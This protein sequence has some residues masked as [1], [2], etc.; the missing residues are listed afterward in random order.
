[1]FL[2]Y[3]NPGSEE[4]IGAGVQNY[5]PS[6]NVQCMFKDLACLP[7]W[8]ADLQDYVWVE[9][10]DTEKY[11]KDMRSLF[12]DLPKLFPAEAHDTEAIPI[13]AAPWGLAPNSLRAYQHLKKQRSLL[14][15]IPEWKDVYRKLVS[16]ETAQEVLQRLTVFL[17]DIQLLETP[18]FCSS[19]EEV[20]HYINKHQ[21]PFILKTPFSSS[22]RGLLWIRSAQLEEK[23]RQWINGAI[24]K[25]GKVSIEPA[26]EKIQDFAMEF[27]SDGKS[28]VD[29]KGLSIFG[30][31]ARG[32]YSGNVLGSE[33][34]R[35]SFLLKFIRK[36][37]LEKIKE[38]LTK[39]LSEIYGTVYTGNIGVDM[40]LY[41]S[42][43]EI[44]IHPC[45][46]INMRQTMGMLAIHLSNRIH[47]KAT[48]LFK[49]EF[50]KAE[51]QVM[52][53]HLSEQRLHPIIMEGGKLQSGYLNLCPIT[54]QTHYWAYIIV[55]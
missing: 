25:Q 34:H 49:I 55:D 32:A 42:G 1:M 20:I 31:Q 27:Q 39:V 13:Q 52:Q 8:Y 24:R 46:E 9:S 16:R 45:V 54:D 6:A 38:A 26:L 41:R 40:F 17:S 12:P 43:N 3:F 36:E 47:E 53:K 5:T 22:G 19:T 50:E 51:G 14:L 28:H 37:S 10:S 35:E 2:H 18:C 44:Q 15:T 21:P 29:Y 48:G 23:E 33:S 11:V 4:A 30:T 7:L